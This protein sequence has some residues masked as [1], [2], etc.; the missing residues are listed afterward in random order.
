MLSCCR[1]G[2][3]WGGSAGSFRVHSPS[4]PIKLKVWLH[5]QI[6]LFIESR[7]YDNIVKAT[8]LRRAP[9]RTMSHHVVSRAARAACGK[10]LIANKELQVIIQHNLPRSTATAAAATTLETA[11]GHR[12]TLCGNLFSYFHYLYWAAAAV[13]VC[14]E[15]GKPM[16][17]N[18]LNWIESGKVKLSIR[19]Q[20]KP[21][22][23][24]IALLSCN[25]S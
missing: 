11:H 22:L 4:L 24:F 13:L 12:A 15:R 21:E 14:I 6:L 9:C 7:K 3:E 2:G 18:E 10:V 17:M 8:T 5:A 16:P 20:I 25:G 19:S 23:R 1:E